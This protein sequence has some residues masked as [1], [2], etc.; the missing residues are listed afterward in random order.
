M[1][2]ILVSLFAV[3][4][5]FVCNAQ[6]ENGT[7]ASRFDALIQRMVEDAHF[8][9][10]YQARELQVENLPDS[11]LPLLKKYEKIPNS[12]AQTWIYTNYY[13]YAVASK[14]TLFKQQMMR[15][16]LNACACID[17]IELSYACGP[18]TGYL[19]KFDNQLFDKEMI[20]T[21]NSRAAHN[22]RAA[23]DY[24]YISG[25]LNQKQMIPAFEQQL[26]TE[27]SPINRFEWNMILAR[28]GFAPSIEVTRNFMQEL[29]IDERLIRYER[30]FFY[31]R[32]KPIIDLLLKDLNSNE[33][34][35]PSLEFGEPPRDGTPYVHYAM[36]LL[37]K[38]VKDFPVIERE[39][40]N[41]ATT[42]FLKKQHEEDWAIARKWAKEHKNNYEIIAE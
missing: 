19:K 22:K 11:L 28:L 20:D 13:E 37:M 31:T 1:K 27:E 38:L 35:E 3:T 24:A 42:E 15:K 32:Q 5:I 12:N 29:S 36:K 17:S 40:D 16:L 34:Q 6:N 10:S 25:K 41:D 39:Y 8:G 26:T 9:Y 14:D 21:I 7:L 23:T 2:K 18:A 33:I 30:V 4:S